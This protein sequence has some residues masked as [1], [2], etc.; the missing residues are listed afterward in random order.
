M[1]LTRGVNEHETALGKPANCPD[2]HQAGTPDQCGLIP[3]IFGLV[4]R[5]V[6]RCN[7][8]PSPLSSNRFPLMIR[9]TSEAIKCWLDWEPVAWVAFIWPVRKADGVL[10]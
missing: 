7:T 10:P 4:H 6:S 3:G 8:L 1:R 9:E 2:T 5:K